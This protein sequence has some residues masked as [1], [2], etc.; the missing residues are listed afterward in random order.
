VQDLQNYM[1]TLEQVNERLQQLLCGAYERT[2]ARAQQRDVDLRTAALL[3][4]VD[5]VARAKLA[6]GLFP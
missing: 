5:R 6:R 2:L 1:W 3:E 4:A